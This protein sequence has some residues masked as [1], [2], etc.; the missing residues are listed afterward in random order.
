MSARI[1]RL[2][3][4]L[5]VLFLFAAF[6]QA[7]E[8]PAPEA[9]GGAEA[10]EGVE[11]SGSATQ[12]DL[13]RLESQVGSLSQEVKTLKEILE[14]ALEPS[15]SR[16]P[17]VPVKSPE[18]I[19]DPA[20]RDYLETT[21]QRIN[22]MSERL[23]GLEDRVHELDGVQG[24][25]AGVIAEPDGQELRVPNILGNMEK[26]PQF[27]EQVSEAVHDV[28]AQE[29]TL[30]IENQTDVWQKLRV[31]NTGRSYDIPPR[32]AL[33]PITVPVGTIST[34]LVNYEAPRNWTVGPPNYEQRI[35]IKPASAS[36]ST[37]RVVPV[38]LPS[39][40]YYEYFDPLLGATVRS[41]WPY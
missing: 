2:C 9:A 38:P 29:G 33:A 4:L 13:E 22:E 21:R 15:T 7:Q 36:I 12:S 14:V 39:I 28:L 23:T 1:A 41:P 19:S 32:T 3:C 17:L 25:I 8:A 27:R 37:L 11:A 24:Q 10:P 18:E 16:P 40:G 30:T 34:E 6:G 20:T 26:S 35:V 5:S 31:A